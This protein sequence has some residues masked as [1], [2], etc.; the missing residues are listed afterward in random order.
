[1]M[2]HILVTGGAG[3]IGSN[4]VRY[5]LDKGL[6]VSVLDS[7]ENAVISKLELL[8]LGV[9]VH[10]LDIQNCQAIESLSGQFD[11][12]VHLAAQVSV[13]KSIQDPERNH[14]VNVS[15]TEHVL[16]FAQQNDV[17]RFIF[18]SSSAVYG[19]CE[20]MPLSES[21]EGELQSPYAKSK[22]EIERK[23]DAYFQQGCEFLSLRFFNVYGPE[24]R[25]DS[26]YGAVVPI[27]IDRY[28][29]GIQPTI[30]GSGNQSRD[31]VNVHDIAR[32][33]VDLSIG[34]WA[35]PKQSVY[36]VGTGQSVTITEL[37]SLIHEL[38][39]TNLA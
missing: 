37:A 20:S 7:F 13:P 33:L 32:L 3:F 24:Q 28:T 27:F 2:K 38:S 6:T 39:Q 26:N 12:I 9:H 25:L 35:Q 30:Y 36:N 21:S 17:K 4:T 23:I 31:F 5:A 10:Q 16:Q 15:G 8:E 14:S 22:L 11:A 19:D 18:A 34:E 29:Q 1:M